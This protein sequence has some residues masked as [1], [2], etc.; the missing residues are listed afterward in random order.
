MDRVD[1]SRG[2]PGYS[3]QYQW[4]SFQQRNITHDATH[5]EIDRQQKLLADHYEKKLLG[6]SS[7]NEDL[8]HFKTQRMIVRDER[9]GHRVSDGIREHL[10]EPLRKV[11]SSTSGHYYEATSPG[12]NIQI[13]RNRLRRKHGC[14]TSWN[15]KQGLSC[16]GSGEVNGRGKC[17]E[18][19]LGAGRKTGLERCLA[20]RSVSLTQIKKH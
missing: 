9:K 1:K 17:D 20:I 8:R 11:R 13:C 7:T 2:S 3:K 19:N 12:T 16:T 6:C 4:T 5:K 10:L 18:D 15:G 14:Q